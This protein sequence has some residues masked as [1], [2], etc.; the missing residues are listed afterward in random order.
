MCTG[1]KGIRRKAWLLAQFQSEKA[2][3]CMREELRTGGMPEVSGRE[4]II[5]GKVSPSFKFR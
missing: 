4:R 1:E 2:V 3:R 5:K